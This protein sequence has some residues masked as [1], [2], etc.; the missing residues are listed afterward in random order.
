MKRV[1]RLTEIYDKYGSETGA[2]RDI[3]IFGSW[4]KDHHWLP[5]LWIKTKLSQTK[6][7]QVIMLKSLKWFSEES[8]LQS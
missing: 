5:N 1:L 8:K 3:Y 7:F 2:C 4:D 6:T